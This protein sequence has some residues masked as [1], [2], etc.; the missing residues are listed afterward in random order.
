MIVFYR[1]AVRVVIRDGVMSDGR[2]SCTDPCPSTVITVGVVAFNEG[3]SI[4]RALKSIQLAIRQVGGAVE[5]I[6]VLT[7][8][9]DQTEAE[10]LSVLSGQPNGRLISVPLRMSKCAALN[11]VKA[12][13]NG[14]ILMFFDADLVIDDNAIMAFSEAYAKDSRLTVAFGRMVPLAGTSHLWTAVGEWTAAALDA[15][16]RLP[17][18]SGLWL[19]CGSIFAVRVDAWTPFPD[20]IMSDD[21]YLG[22]SAQS[23]GLYVRYLPQAIAY[24]RYPQNLGD[25]TAQKLRNRF[26]RIQLRMLPGQQFRHTPIWFGPFA[27][28]RLGWDTFRHLPILLI[29]GLLSAVALIQWIFGRRA[30]AFWGQVASTKLD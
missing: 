12:H 5:L 10:A 28:R 24:G 30:G 25:Y 19:V 23:R 16:R 9:T 6:V 15:I 2:E 13:A 26:A 17:D 18:G 11:V 3:K 20:G 21:L 14:R 29:D 1:T 8:C 27:L 4:A 22:L 7:G